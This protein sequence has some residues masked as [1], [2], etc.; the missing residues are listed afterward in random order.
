M[1]MA[2]QDLTFHTVSQ[3]I[4]G[5]GLQE[6]PIFDGEKT[7]KNMVS[8]RLHGWSEQ[9]NCRTTCPLFG[10]DSAI[11]F[12]GQTHP[13]T[14][15]NIQYKLKKN[16]HNLPSKGTRTPSESFYTCVDWYVPI[17]F[18]IHTYIYI[19]LHITYIYIYISHIYIYN[20]IKWVPPVVSWLITP[21]NCIGIPL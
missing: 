16:N 21:S 12:I 14:K 18:Y 2:I 9:A 17:F 4:G 7:W 1:L 13:N 11:D 20:A 19:Y 10:G 3:G 6:L 5:E 8:R 15:L